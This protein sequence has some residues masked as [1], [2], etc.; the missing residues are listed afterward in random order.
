MHAS[1]EF[2][3]TLC[4]NY[5][6]MQQRAALNRLKKRIRK[7]PALLHT[8]HAGEVPLEVVVY[9]CAQTLVNSHGS[10]EDVHAVLR[11]LVAEAYTDADMG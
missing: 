1:K 3:P 5:P 7:N 6:V 9:D 11:Y 8:V 4:Y 10:V 2:I